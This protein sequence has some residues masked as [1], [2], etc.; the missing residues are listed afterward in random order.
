MAGAA[1]PRRIGDR[2][3]KLR[4]MTLSKAPSRCSVPRQLSFS[5]ALGPSARRETRILTFPRS[6][7]RDGRIS[8]G[9]VRL[10]IVCRYTGQPD[11]GVCR[12]GAITKA[13]RGITSRYTVVTSRYTVVTEPLLIL[14]AVTELDGSKEPVPYNGIHSGPSLPRTVLPLGLFPQRPCHRGILC[15]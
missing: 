4:V 5:R 3:T 14:R 9:Q 1:P 8:R 13:L 7:G 11:F 10:L 15:G 2:S 6:R 12:R